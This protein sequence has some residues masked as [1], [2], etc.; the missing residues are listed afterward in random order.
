MVASQKRKL[1][2]QQTS[3][4][5]KKVTRGG[6][7]KRQEDIENWVSIC[8]FYLHCCLFVCVCVCVCL[9]VCLFVCS[10]VC[11]FVC[12]FLSAFFYPTFPLIHLF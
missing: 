7:Q 5:I 4:M 6:A 1:T 9:F 8:S 12:L 11:L 10:F 2:E 3:E